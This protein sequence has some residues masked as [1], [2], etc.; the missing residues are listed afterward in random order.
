M[1]IANLI[2]QFGG[3]LYTLL[4]FVLA[5]SIIVAIH[6]YGHY[7]VGRWTGI[8]ADVFSLGF[9]PVLVSRTDRRGTRWQIAAL[10]FGGYVKFKGDS[11]A[12][13]VG[14]DAAVGAG[15]DTMAGA[16]LWARAL[17]VAAGPVANF[18]FS[19]VVF[20]A[21]Y[22]V[23]GQVTDQ[24][25]IGSLPSL[26]PAIVQDLRAGD[27]ILQVDGQA[28]DSPQA[29][30]D[31][32]ENVTIASTVPYLVERDGQQITIDGP[33]PQLPFASG[34]SP[35]SAAYRAGIEAGDLIVA[36]DG[37]P[38]TAF[39]ELK[40]AVE[41]SEG[42]P[43]TLTL[44]RDGATQEVEL[45]AKRTDV[46]KADGGFETRWL[47]G[48]TG[49]LFFEPETESVPPVT[50]AWTAVR[51]VGSILSESISGIWHMITGAISSCNL[52]SP[53]GIAETSGAMASQGTVSFVFFIAFLST[54]VGLFNLF[55]V[56]VL[57]GGHL[58]FYA[59]EAVTG[60]PPSDR[61]LHLLMSIGLSLILSLMVFALLNDL[62]LC[63]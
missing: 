7:I 55:P 15:R 42:A 44:W 11:N 31:A 1:D 2:P 57:D 63:P 3:V 19:A 14:A 50:A 49:G 29:Y 38:I 48:I 5:L 34:I 37:A 43:V 40:T 59:W 4:A 33:Y 56:P 61:A 21:M 58:V 52:S 13:S 8:K 32:V 30:F 10:P 25:R 45:A 46:P 41:A 23:Q 22:L 51:Q 28:A 17:T 62:V 6:E 60:S 16:P 53:V 24:M 27:H 36:V 18:I 20:F 9:G 54:A 47:I 12:A 26:P 35:R 39:S